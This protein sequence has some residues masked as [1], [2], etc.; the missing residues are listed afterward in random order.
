MTAI[1]FPRATQYKGTYLFRHV[2]SLNTMNPFDRACLH[3]LPTSAIIRPAGQGQ[4]TIL[5]GENQPMNK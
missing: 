5:S 3:F 2:K 4:K 1:S